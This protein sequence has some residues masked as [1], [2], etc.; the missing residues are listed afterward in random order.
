M[1]DTPPPVESIGPLQ[2][3]IMLHI[4]EDSGRGWT[5]HDVHNLLNQQRSE[6]AKPQLAYTTVLTVMRNLRR[7]NLLSQQDNGARAHIFRPLISRADY[8]RALLT[9]VASS[10]YEGDVEKFVAA[11][12]K[13]RDAKVE[14]KV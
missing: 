14:A 12:I 7:R 10:L 9:S 6:A 3:E 8:E 11:V 4:W 13:F 2:T 1:S 5:V